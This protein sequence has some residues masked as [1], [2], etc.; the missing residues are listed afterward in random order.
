MASRADSARRRLDAIVRA[1]AGDRLSIQAVRYLVIGGAGYLF[2]LAVYALEL[3]LG[4]P[5]YPAVAVVFVANG[6]FNFVLMRAW[7]FPSSGRHVRSEFGRFCVVAG[8]SLI[9]NY[10]SFALLYSVLG[11]PA[12]IA[13]GLAILIAAP[14]G[15]LANRRWSFGR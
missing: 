11:V 7:A 5:A 12:L 8:A 10:S 6:L 13:Q 9:V 15:F 2:A 4:V 3:A 1:P 14:V